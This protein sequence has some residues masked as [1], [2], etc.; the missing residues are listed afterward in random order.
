MSCP[1][2][3]GE[4][5]SHHARGGVSTGDEVKHTTVEVFPHP[6][7]VQVPLPV[8]F[9]NRWQ[10]MRAVAPPARNEVLTGRDWRQ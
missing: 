3:M 2:G 9:F 6:V 10:A 4:T 5:D 1:T 7:G 8:P